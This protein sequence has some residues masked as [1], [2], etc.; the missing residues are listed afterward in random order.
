VEQASLRRVLPSTIEVRSPSGSRWPRPN[1]RSPV[2]GRC[3][4]R[5]SST[6]TD[7]TTRRLDLPIVDGLADAPTGAPVVDEAR[8]ALA[9]R[10]IAALRS[11]PR[12][13]AV[14]QIDVQNARD[15]IVLLDGDQARLR[16]G[17]DEFA[18][19][20]QAYLELAPALRQRV[21][22]IDYVD[23]RFENRVYVRPGATAGA[24]ASSEARRGRRRSGGDPRQPRTPCDGVP[25]RRR[26]ATWDA[27]TIRRR[28]RRRHLEG[29]RRRRR[30][31]RERRPRRRR[32]RR[33]RL[34]RHPQGRRHQPRGG[35]RV[36]QEGDRGGGADGGRRDRL[37]A[38]GGLRPAHQ[39]LQ[40]PR[41]DCRGRQEPRDHARRRAAGDRRREGRVA[42]ERARDPPRAAAGL[43]RGRAGW[44]RRAGRA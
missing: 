17:D 3:R 37:G 21:P 18:E 26:R 7:R 5:G 31:A 32:H 34:R 6:S 43:R 38:P 27:G 10:L 23:M 42:A 30:D 41:R 36:D 4:G 33:D 12:S 25:S 22:D 28:P 8:A 16:L 2:P 14:S 19:R 15:A 1:R 44:D 11:S 39:G 20:L 29:L 40:Q 13:S 35:R 24:T 9:A